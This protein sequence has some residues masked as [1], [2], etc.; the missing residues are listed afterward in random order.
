[1]SEL[2]WQ[3]LVILGVQLV[4]ILSHWLVCLAV[5]WTEGDHLGRVSKD[6]DGLT[7]RKNGLGLLI[8]I[9]RELM[10]LHFSRWVGSRHL[11]LSWHRTLDRRGS[12]SLEVL[13]L[14]SQLIELLS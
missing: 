7:G 11:N 1:M 13:G 4:Q 10:R 3:E 14:V 12:K 5:Q 8:L 6:L 9:L 2:C